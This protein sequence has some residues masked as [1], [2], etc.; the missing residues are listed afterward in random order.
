LAKVLL[1]MI[2][3]PPTSQNWEKRKAKKSWCIDHNFNDL[4]NLCSVTHALHLIAACSFRPITPS[5]MPLPASHPTQPPVLLATPWKL[6][7]FCCWQFESLFLSCKMILSLLH[8]VA[9]M[10]NTTIFQLQ[11]QVFLTPVLIPGSLAY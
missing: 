10:M 9:F 11:G 1:W 2:D 3:S 8:S 5:C 4:C 6:V 7:P